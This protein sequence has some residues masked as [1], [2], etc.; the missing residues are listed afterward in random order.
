M[1]VVDNRIFD[2]QCCSLL[3][4]VFSRCPKFHELDL[5]EVDGKTIRVFEKGASKW[6]RIATRLHFE[7]TKIVQIRTDCQHDTFQAC[8]KTFTEWLGGKEGLRTPIAWSTVIKVLEEADLC[9]PAKDLKEIL[10]LFEKDSGKYYIPS[11][12]ALNELIVMYIQHIR[13]QVSNNSHS[14]Q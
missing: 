6:D 3:Y 5:I 4:I 2:H 7:G 12:F 1:Y 9:Q 14:E 10:F 8:Q 13:I 11:P